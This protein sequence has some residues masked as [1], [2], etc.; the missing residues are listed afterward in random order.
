[1]GRT[2]RPLAGERAALSEAAGD[3]EGPGPGLRW[4]AG[5]QPEEA[6]GGERPRAGAEAGAGPIRL[7]EA[8]PGPAVATALAALHDDR[9]GAGTAIVL[10]EILG[11]PRFRSAWRPSAPAARWGAMRAR[12]GGA[13]TSGPSNRGPSSGGASNPA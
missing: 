12:T 8:S 5:D 1:M 3:E 11:P 7:T 6:L 2:A 9:A 4:M 10:A 13:S